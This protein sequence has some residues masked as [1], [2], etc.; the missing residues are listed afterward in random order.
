MT[1]TFGQVFC[2]GVAEETLLRALRAVLAREGYAPFEATRIPPGYPALAQEVTRIAVSEAGARDTR[3]VLFEDWDLTF[4]RALALSREVAGRDFVAVVRPP[5]EPTRVKAYRDGGVVLKVGQ[6]PDEEVLYCPAV[7][8]SEDV[9][10]YLAAWQ[11]D[12][13]PSLGI[14][15]SLADI[16]RDCSYRE[17][18]AGDW[19]VPLREW[20]FLSQRSRLFL[21]S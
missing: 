8:S 12:A 14:L 11:P 2:R 18:M 19:P 6:D 13:D 15:G 5:L 3:A 9:R 16:R 4:S 10:L 7:S 1:L 21:E 20:V 17:A